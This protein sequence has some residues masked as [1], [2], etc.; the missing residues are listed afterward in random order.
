ML[1]C[2]GRGRLA[3]AW[4]NIRHTETPSMYARSTPKPMMR[5]VNT[6]MINIV[7]WLPRRIDVSAARSP[8]LPLRVDSVVSLPWSADG[9]WSASPILTVCFVDRSPTLRHRA[10]SACLEPRNCWRDFLWVR[11][12]GVGRDTSV[13]NVEL[14]P[15]AACR[16]LE[17]RPL[18]DLLYGQEPSFKQNP[19]H[20]MR[21][22]KSGRFST[23]F[24]N[25][26]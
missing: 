15:V 25:L 26:D 3:T 10:T 8:E 23:D 5:R 12:A 17:K 1:R 11:M 13:A 7:D 21:L 4:L 18:V 16:A 14:R 9:R 19:S 24:E 22:W 6:S 20:G 2:F